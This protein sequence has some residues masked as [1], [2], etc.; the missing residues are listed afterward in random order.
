PGSIEVNAWGGP[1]K[2]FQVLV[3][4]RRLVAHGLTIRDGQGALEE[5]NRSAGG[6]DLRLGDEPQ[7]VRGVGVIRDERDIRRIAVAAQDAT[8]V[9]HHDGATVPTGPAI[10]QGALTTN[11]EGEAVAAVTMLLLGENGRVVVERVKDRVTEI[12][13]TL[14]AGTELV[15]YMD[16]SEL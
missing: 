10:R 15:G 6:A 1:E 14:P 11:G 7:L 12:Q 3:D 5:N 2:Q 16:R 9:H 4:P 8:P 13:K